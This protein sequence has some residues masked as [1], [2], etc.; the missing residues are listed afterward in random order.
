MNEDAKK[1]KWFYFNVD[2][3]GLPNY[4]RNETHHKKAPLG[5]TKEPPNTTIVIY[6]QSHGDSFRWTWFKISVRWICFLLAKA[7]NRVWKGILGIRD[8][9]KIPC[10]NREN[11]KYLDGIRDLTALRESGARQN[12]GMGCGI[13]SPVC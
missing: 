6:Q 9:T 12:L 10:G 2:M 13:S 7:N 3:N 1:D 8:L 5:A 11:D 4:Q